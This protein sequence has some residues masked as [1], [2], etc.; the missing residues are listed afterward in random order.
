MG[1]KVRPNRFALN[2]NNNLRL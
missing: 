1:F 2:D